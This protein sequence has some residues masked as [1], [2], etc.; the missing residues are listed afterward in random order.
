[1]SLL[2]SS[3][4]GVSCA[5]LSD[6]AI[7]VIRKD[8]MKFHPLET[9]GILIGCYDENY[10]MAT[11]HE[12]IP[13]PSDS[14]HGRTYFARG[15]AGV[16]DALNRA[17]KR[18]PSLHYLGEWHSHPNS[19]PLPSGVDRRQMQQFARNRQHGIKAPLLLI[20][21]GSL[22]DALIWRFT[23]HQLKQAQITLSLV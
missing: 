14:K 18:D 15:T 21:G 8:I 7:D 6:S 17:R 9:G 13:A 19:L 23:L 20:V 10:R 22:T 5:L 16:L 11:V 2:F 4:D 3:G 1:M 12:A